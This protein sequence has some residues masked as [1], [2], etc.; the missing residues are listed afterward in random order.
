MKKL[1]RVCSIFL[2]CV[3]SPCFAAVISPATQLQDVANKMISQLESNKAQLH[4]MS[5]IRGIVNRVLIPTVDMNRMSVAVVGQYWRTATPAQKA[6]FEKDFAYMVTTTYAS[7]L[8]S[9]DGDVVTFQP[10][11]GDFSS[12]Q[13]TRVN[14]IIA[15]K[16]GQRIPIT[17]DVLR[18]GNQWKVYD[19]SIEHVSMVQ[20]Y[21]SQFS[22]VL[23]QGGM[24]ALLAR[25][26]AHNNAGK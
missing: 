19:F 11:R 1:L 13:A 3:V 25:L 12:Q 10:L 17:Y 18:K 15:R 20:S 8:A 2:F 4:N 14:S 6:Q 26:Q 16:N 23:A 5:V 7:A 22:D 21:H 24:P 9:Y